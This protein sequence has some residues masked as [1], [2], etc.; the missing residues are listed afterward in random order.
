MLPQADMQNKHQR[1]QRR[2][3][4]AG[5]QSLALRHSCMVVRLAFLFPGVINRT[6]LEALPFPPR[7]S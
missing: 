4:H 7:T 5:E 3:I 1:V 2:M 6:T